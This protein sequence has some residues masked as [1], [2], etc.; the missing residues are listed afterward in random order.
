MV[1]W[2]SCRYVAKP[3]APVSTT[4][5]GTTRTSANPTRRNNPYICRPIHGFG[6]AA[7]STSARRRVSCV[8]DR[9]VG[10][11]VERQDRSPGPHH[12][13]HLA[14]GGFGIAQVAQD[15]LG[16]AQVERVFRKAEVVGVPDLVLAREPG[17]GGATPRFGDHGRIRVDADR[18]PATSD[19]L[20]K[21]GQLVPQAAADVQDAIPGV[22]RT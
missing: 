12:A 7:S 15:A 9:L 19:P 4:V 13:S 22:D 3:S 21:P 10:I 2:L 18:T 20:G 16:S 17:L 6:T 11:E 14:H 1:P 5:C 8:D